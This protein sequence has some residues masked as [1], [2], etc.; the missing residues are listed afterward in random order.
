MALVAGTGA[1]LVRL[2]SVQKLGQPGLKLTAQNVYDEDGNLIGTN[3]VF[4]PERVLD[5]E[6]SPVPVRQAEYNWLPKDTTYGRRLFKAADGFETLLS[7]VL[8]GT[9]R[10]SIHKPEYCVT[11]QGW[12][13]REKM[14][15]KVPVLRPYPYDLP[16]MRLTLV[17]QAPSADGR[18]LALSGLYVYWFVDDRQLTADHKERMWWLARDLVRTG[19]LSRWAYVTCFAVCT[20]GQEGITFER[21]KNFIAEAVPEF[22]LTAGPRVAKEAKSFDS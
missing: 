16:V 13:I 7:V 22:Q 3:A 1:L 4:L 8:M 10:T 17:G 14:K 2:R 6:S 15:V 5:Y 19:T 20:P 9:D 12:V 21:M 11:G 18:P